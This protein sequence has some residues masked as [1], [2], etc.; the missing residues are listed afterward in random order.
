MTSTVLVT[1]ATGF[2]GGAVTR[3]LLGT[4]HQVVALVRDEAAAGPLAAAGARLAVGDLHRPETL[5]T[6]VPGVDAVVHTAQLRVR[7]AGARALRRIAAAD[8]VATAALAEACLAAGARLVYTSGAMVWGDHGED[9]IDERT[10]MTP[11]PLG[12]GK[13]AVVRRL[14]ALQER[15]LDSVVLHL[16]FVYGA[17]STFRTAFY[18]PA[19]RGLLRCIGPG[20]N[21]WSP[22]HVDDV[23]TAFVAALERAPAGAEYAVADDQ[24]L[25]LRALVDQL[26]DA[27]GRRRVGSVPPWLV[28][29]VAGA[30]TAV[31]LATSYRTSN[32]KARA[33]LGWTPGHPTFAAGLPAA[34]AA[35]AGSAR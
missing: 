6:A 35:L 26:T 15:G 14:R 33:E 30:P 22:V 21:Y 13:A 25:P 9:W 2:V 8:R 10:P 23:A 11:S 31:S 7:R 5:R 34:L 19:R 29:L 28:G 1:G 16:G 3:A 24:P 17:G 4:G 20:D 32:A 12:V 27:L 18:Q